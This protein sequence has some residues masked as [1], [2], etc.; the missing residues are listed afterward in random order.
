[1]NKYTTD[2][3]GKWLIQGNARLLIEPSESYLA[4]MELERLQQEEQERL[5]NLIPSQFEELSSYVLDVD[6]RVIMLE[7]GM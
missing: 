1:M 3:Q 2:E 7:M 5:N 4:Q 6:F